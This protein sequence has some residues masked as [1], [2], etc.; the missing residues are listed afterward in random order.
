MLHDQVHLLK[1]LLKQ[2]NYASCAYCT[3]FN[4]AYL[5]TTGEGGE[6]QAVK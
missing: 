3:D 2:Y 5:M 6:I 1:L 4:L